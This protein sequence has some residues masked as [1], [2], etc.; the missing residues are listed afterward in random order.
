VID[1]VLTLYRPVE[2]KEALL[3]LEADFR[4]FPPRRPEQP[5]FYPVLNFEYA[6]QIVRDWNTKSPEAGFVAFVTQFRIDEAYIK[7]FEEQVVGA[8]VHR[9]L[10]IPAER[11]DEFNQHIQGQIEI[12]TAYYGE[13]TKARNTSLQTFMLMRCSPCFIQCH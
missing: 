12:I 5:I 7:Q 8:S 4:E 1:A 11:L 9:E 13:A 2:L 10:W 6:E 3:I